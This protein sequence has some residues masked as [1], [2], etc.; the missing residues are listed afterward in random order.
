MEINHI[1][2][3][4]MYC[5][6]AHYPNLTFTLTISNDSS[7]I[8]TDNKSKASC[9]INQAIKMHYLVFSHGLCL[10]LRYHQYCA[11]ILKVFILIKTV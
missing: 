6:I 1:S 2:P 8:L 5:N 10:C 7:V 4:K 11:A 9:I 3:K